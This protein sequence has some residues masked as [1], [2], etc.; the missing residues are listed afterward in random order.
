MKARAI[1]RFTVAYGRLRL[2]VRLLPTIADVDAEY[3]SGQRR[4][5]GEIVHA[6]FAPANS[7]T[8]AHIGTIVLPANGRLA[9]L[10]PHESTH[11]AM[12]RI[13][14]VHC[15]ADERLATTVGLLSA[16]IFA[17]LKRRGM[18]V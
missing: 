16:R 13:G 7:A 11:A 12:H 14:G 9:E 5:N 8:A 18:E 3:R 10:V 6:F 17:G 1:A 15:T 2:R 4:R